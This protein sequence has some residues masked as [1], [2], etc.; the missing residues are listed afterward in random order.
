MISAGSGAL[1]GGLM[2]GLSDREAGYNFWSGSKIEGQLLSTNLA[3]G[4]TYD[5]SSLKNMA[6]QAKADAEYLWGVKSGENGLI[7][8]STTL[9]AN[10]RKGGYNYNGGMFV[11]TNGQN[12]DGFAISFSSGNS[13]VFI[14]PDVTAS[15]TNGYSSPCYSIMKLGTN[16]LSIEILSARYV[17]TLGH[18]LIQ[19]L[20]E[21]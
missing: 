5:A 14:S 16:G 1:L 13:K 10:A 2:Q 17:S 11:A 9:D 12:V 8:I 20:I 6:N 18:E 7:G 15:R 21:E 3:S 4:N 19:L